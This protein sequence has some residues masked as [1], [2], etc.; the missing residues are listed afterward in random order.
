LWFVGFQ[1]PEGPKQTARP[2]GHGSPVSAVE[3]A[4]E[5][6]HLKKK[7]ASEGTSPIIV[8]GETEKEKVFA[9]K[10]GGRNGGTLIQQL[11]SD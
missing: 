10:R 3:E 2:V 9:G 8:A 1:S 6:K 7:R 4:T 11:K 5:Q